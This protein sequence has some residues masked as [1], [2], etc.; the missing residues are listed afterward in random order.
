MEKMIKLWKD[1]RLPG[2]PS[3]LRAPPPLP[4]TVP[5]CSRRDEGHLDPDTPQPGCSDVRIT[6]L[7]G[8]FQY[9]SQGHKASTQG[10]PRN[11]GQVGTPCPWMVGN[12]RLLGQFSPSFSKP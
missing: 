8:K 3:F 9:L 12:S 7:H 2:A 1:E 5:A 10:P 6:D 4:Q 11:P